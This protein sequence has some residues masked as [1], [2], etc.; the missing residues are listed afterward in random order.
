MAL[1]VIIQLEQPSTENL[2]AAGGTV[3]AV[4][5]GLMYIVGLGL[6]CVQLWTGKTDSQVI[7]FFTR[8]F[9]EDAG[10]KNYLYYPAVL[11]MRALVPLGYLSL[12]GYPEIVFGIVMFS[13]CFV[14]VLLLMTSPFNSILDTAF[15]VTYHIIELSLVAFPI[16][17]DLGS[18]SEVLLNAMLLLIVFVGL[19]VCVIKFFLDF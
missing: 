4:G 1:Y 2:V 12:S 19:I 6:L 10:I 7:L 3:V 8:E 14:I 9:K 16:I 18:L 5:L 11:T 15:T 13:E 17:Y